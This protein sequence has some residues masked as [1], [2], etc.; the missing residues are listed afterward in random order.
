MQISTRGRYGLRAMVDMALHV[1]EGPMALRVIAERQG[2]SESYLEQVFTSLRKSGLVR[3]SRGAQG[4]YELNRQPDQVTVGE[5]LRAL[6]GQLVPVYCV[7]ESEGA[8]CDREQYCITR[9]FWEELR[10]KINE[11]LDGITLKDLADR[12]K[13]TLPEEPM[14]YI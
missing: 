4:G 3:A 8:S 1:S 14:Y 13:A 7:G 12:A 10:D 11:F 5:I 2:I 9:S 6:E